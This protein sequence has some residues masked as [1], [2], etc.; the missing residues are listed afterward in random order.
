M[1][2]GI[3]RIDKYVIPAGGKY[4]ADIES[5]AGSLVFQELIF[6][7]GV[8]PSGRQGISL[9]IP[10]DGA[11]SSASGTTSLSRC[12]S[13]RKYSFGSIVA[14]N[15]QNKVLRQFEGGIYF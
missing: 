12:S 2:G 7:R 15:L 10:A 1:L 11:A 14:G 4:V 13:R 5:Q 3:L 8:N 6:K 9:G